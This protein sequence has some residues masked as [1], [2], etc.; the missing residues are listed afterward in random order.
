MEIIADNETIKKPSPPHHSDESFGGLMSN[1]P[2]VPFGQ[3][4][5]DFH[6]LSPVY[7]KGIEIFRANKGEVLW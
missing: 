2:T 4:I 7:D 6:S 3:P 1:V 5:E